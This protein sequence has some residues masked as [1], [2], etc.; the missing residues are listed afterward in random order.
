MLT[1]DP[2]NKTIDIS[3]T[4]G[5]STYSTSEIIEQMEKVVKADNR[6]KLNDFVDF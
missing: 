2:T 6:G 1:Q 5:D 4:I 3:P